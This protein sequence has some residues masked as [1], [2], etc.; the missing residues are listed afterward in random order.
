MLICSGGKAILELWK[1]PQAKKCKIE[2]LN[3]IDDR[4]GKQRLM[5]SPSRLSFMDRARYGLASS[6]AEL[7]SRDIPNR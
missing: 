4:E 2:K 5:G 6:Q 1:F 7:I 3:R